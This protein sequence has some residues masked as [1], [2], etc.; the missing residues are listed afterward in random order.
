VSPVVVE[1][2]IKIPFAHW[3]LGVD[4]VKRQGNRGVTPL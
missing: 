3:I 2:F 1:A 4:F